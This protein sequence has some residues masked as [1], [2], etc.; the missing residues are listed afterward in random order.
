MTGAAVAPAENLTRGS[1][2]TIKQGA[3]GWVVGNLAASPETFGQDHAYRV[4]LRV[5][6]N[7]SRRDWETGIWTDGAV[8]GID[9][10]CWGSLAHNVAG[11][12]Q[13][14][15]PVIAY[16]KLSENTWK[17]PEGKSRSRIRL[18]ADVVAHDLNRGSCRFTKINNGSAAGVTN[19]GSD[20]PGSAVG[21]TDPSASRRADQREEKPPQ[22]PWAQREATVS[23]LFADADERNRVKEPEPAPF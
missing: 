16:G 10:T 20:A 2:M 18:V 1:A 19:G 9:V 3:M 13:K 15:D 11:S 22:D 7:S 5:L 21:D 4:I 8:T 17:D 6:S 23:P 12:M 14:G